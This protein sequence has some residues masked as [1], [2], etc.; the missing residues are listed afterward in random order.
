MGFRFKN[1]DDLFDRLIISLSKNGIGYSWGVPGTGITYVKDSSNN[2]RIKENGAS[3][4]RYQTIGTYNE[5]AF[6]NLNYS[7]NK[8]DYI[9]RGIEDIKMQNTFF[10]AVAIVLFFVFLYSLLKNYYSAA[11]LFLLCFICSLIAVIIV[12]RK[13]VNVEYVFE[14]G[15]ENAYSELEAFFTKLMSSNYLWQ[16]TY[17]TKLSDHKYHAG[18]NSSLR[19]KRTKV[20][21]SK[22]KYLKTNVNIYSLVLEE[23]TYYFLPDRILIASTK[24]GMSNKY[25]DTI[26]GEFYLIE[27]VE[28]KIRP[29]DARQVSATWQYV[30]KDGGPDLRFKNNPLM[31]VYEYGAVNLE[32][33]N[34]IDI[35]LDISNSN[36]IPI[37]K[38][39]FDNFKKYYK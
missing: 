8:D 22:I 19:R 3:Q 16:V 32:G 33:N 26:E 11:L 35:H 20:A 25:Y 38:L 21:L 29:S 27:F 13:K 39:K 37:L 4:I 15:T 7:E 5:K 2:S 28:S 18:S 30:N 12:S 34:G 24:K 17:H 10:V 23:G 9:I 14:D 31:P 6:K 1:S 36:L